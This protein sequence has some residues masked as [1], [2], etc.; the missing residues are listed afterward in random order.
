MNIRS[1]TEISANIPFVKALANLGVDKSVEFCN[2]VGLTQIE[3]DE[4]LS[5]GLGGL[6]HG[7][8]VYQM[9]AAYSAIANDGVY[10]EPT[11]YTKV[12]D[13]EGN[14]LYESKQKDEKV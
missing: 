9:A 3:G 12:T 6:T 5:L 4:G 13:K 10:K 7:V 2:S 8:S 1:A 14:V 11:F